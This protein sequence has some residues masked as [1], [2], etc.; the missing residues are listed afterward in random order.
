MFYIM[1]IVQCLK[2]AASSILSKLILIFSSW[3]DLVLVML[4]W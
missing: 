3:R 2:S 1:R 4:S